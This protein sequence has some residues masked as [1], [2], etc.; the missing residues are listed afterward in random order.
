MKILYLVTIPLSA[1]AFLDG[2]LAYLSKQGH[3]VHLA[4]SYSES[5]NLSEFAKSQGIT[6]HY[7]PFVR[8]ISIFND[9]KALIATY[10]LIKAVKPD[11]VNSGTPK[12]GLIGTVVSRIL[13]V[14]KVIYTLHG[15]RFQTVS[16]F[17]RSILLLME[18]LACQ[19][20]DLI[21]CVSNSL[22]DEAVKLGLS[23]RGKFTVI[24]HGT[25]NGIDLNRYIE[26]GEHSSATIKQKLRNADSSR[27]VGY[28][29]RLSADKGIEELYESFK[30]VQEKIEGIK[31]LLIGPSDESD[32]I[33]ESL[34]QKISNDPDVIMTGFLSDVAHYYNVMEFLVLPSRREGYGMVILEAAAAGIT[35]IGANVTGIIDAIIDQKSGL[36]YKSG[37]KRDLSEKMIY[38]L[39]N[40]K[41]RS[42]MANFAKQR[43]REDFNREDIWQELNRIYNEK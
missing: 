22:K 29:G 30:I 18:K 11:V 8:E 4:S 26:I 14:N 23:Q 12:A 10:N 32:P 16:G 27:I 7:I 43:V 21:I 24:N 3:E 37:D 19:N 20:A 33:E 2:Q 40:P 25:A 35:S 38:L 17:K 28:V 9:V 15:I 42:Q 31:L 34:S 36:I 13:R 39:S 6:H 1:S 41:K 5:P